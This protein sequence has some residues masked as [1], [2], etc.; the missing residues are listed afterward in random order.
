MNTRLQL[1]ASA[2]LVAMLAAGCA[3]MQGLAPQASRN[4]AAGLAAAGSIA[5]TRLSPA[6]W[7]A[8]DWWKRYNDPQLDALMNEALAGSPTLR[9]A[10]ARARQ[11]LAFA[12][13]LKAPL[14]P[15][16]GGTAGLTRERFPEHGLIP[17]PF[18]GAWET[19]TQLQA[20]LNYELDLWGKNRAAYDSALGQAKAAE[21][22]AYAARL[23]LS[24]DI[25]HAYVQ[26]ERAFLQRD[27]AEKALAQQEHIYALTRERF[28]AGIDS[29]LA[30]K[31]AEAALP[32]TRERIAQLQETIGLM[33]NEIA[34]LMGEG[35]DR[36]LAI[37][38]PAAK[39][40]GPVEIPSALPAALIGRRPD[41]VAQR[42]RVEAARK[43][44]EVAKTQFYPNVSLTAFVG[45]QSI[46]LPGFLTAQSRTLGA[47]PALTLPIFDN[48]RLRGNLAGRD[49]QYDAAVE[50]YNQKLVDALRDVVDQLTSF[51]SLDEQRRQ[52]RLAQATAQDAYDLALL[53]FRAGTSNYL[54]VL[55]AQSQLLAQESFAAD[56][57]ARALDLS[58]NLVRALG[59]GFDDTSTAAARTARASH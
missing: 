43:D 16:A 6:A 44:I 19:Q 52:Q 57:R 27:V 11:A 12:Q 34:A 54:E 4:D 55:T 23:A 1:T 21:I 51:R 25:A 28:E 56:L 33:R 15:Q 36:G 42:W 3:D 29:R 35:P 46:G 30:V 53:R 47:G 39:V 58:I 24:V 13:T 37:R 26:L 49:A 41:I 50:V 59:G 31:Q 14:Y 10:E 7:P 38:R 18:A 8:T 40:L 20:T 48:I 17:P 45:L 5:N 22:D 2:L 32:A 9:M